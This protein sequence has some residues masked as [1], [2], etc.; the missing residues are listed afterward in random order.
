VLA[1]HLFSILQDCS[2]QQVHRDVSKIGEIIPL[3]AVVVSV[4]VVDGDVGI[5]LLFGYYLSSSGELIWTKIMLSA[6]SP[7]GLIDRMVAGRGE[8]NGHVCCFFS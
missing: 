1:Q 3:Q 5:F 8:H 4:A 7:D 2:C 6:G